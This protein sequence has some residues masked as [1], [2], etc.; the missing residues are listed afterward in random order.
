VKLNSFI[1]DGTIPGCTIECIAKRLGRSHDVEDRPCL[2]QVG[3]SGQVEA[4]QIVSE[5]LR[6]KLQEFDLTTNGHSG[7]RFAQDIFR[8]AGFSEQGY[9]VGSCLDDALGGKPR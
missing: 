8:D 9:Y 3:I 5:R 1:D 4:E 7:I 2:S 6:G